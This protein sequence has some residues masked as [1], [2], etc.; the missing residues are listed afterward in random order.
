MMCMKNTKIL[1]GLIVFNCTYKLKG[2]HDKLRILH[3]QLFS[4]RGTEHFISCISDLYTESDSTSWRICNIDWITATSYYFIFYKRL[5]LQFGKKKIKALRIRIVMFGNIQMA[6]S[7]PT[8]NCN[9][10]KQPHL[11][12]CR[13]WFI[14]FG[15]PKSYFRTLLVITSYPY[16]LL[17][18][19]PITSNLL[20]RVRSRHV[21]RGQLPS[22]TKNRKLMCQ[23]NSNLR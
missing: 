3:S 4:I 22:K 23:N 2:E 10:K 11:L 17:L 1:D 15:C 20:A 21:H 6:L 8:P 18:L 9:E 16:G 5:R 7:I 12:V 14:L 19:C 13:S